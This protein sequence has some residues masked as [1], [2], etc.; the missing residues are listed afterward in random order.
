ME[1]SFNKTQKLGNNKK[2]L[3]NLRLRVKMRDQTEIYKN[4]N[5]KMK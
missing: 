2:N 1:K 5:S 4:E 3:S